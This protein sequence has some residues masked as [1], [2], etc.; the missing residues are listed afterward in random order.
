MS[1]IPSQTFVPRSNEGKEHDSIAQ[2]GKRL[3]FELVQ[4]CKGMSPASTTVIGWTTL[5]HLDSHICCGWQSIT[6]SCCS[7]ARGRACPS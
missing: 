5:A 4:Y 1:F 7:P 2:L 6:R 3:A